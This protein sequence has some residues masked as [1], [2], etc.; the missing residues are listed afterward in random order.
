MKWLFPFGFILLCFQ[1]I[2]AQDAEVINLIPN[3]DFEDVKKLTANSCDIAPKVWQFSG[4]RIVGDAAG[5]NC[6]F[7]IPDT[8]NIKGDYSAGL[9]LFNTDEY[10][11]PAEKSYREYLHIVLKEPLKPGQQYLVKLNALPFPTNI[12]ANNSLGFYFSE[13]STFTT[14]PLI[15][16]GISRAPQ[17]IFP[18]EIGV[19]GTWVSH[20]FVFKP[21]REYTHLTIG[22]F[23]NNSKTRF[24]R[25]DPL[26]EKR[27]L[28][29]GFY[30]LDN[31]ELFEYD[32]EYIQEET[33]PVI[34]ENIMSF[35]GVLFET[36]STT[37]TK[38]F[39]RELI[40]LSIFLIANQQKNITIVGHTDNSGAEALN[41]ELSLQ[42]SV[43][44][45]EFL[46]S[47]SVQPNRI[48]TVGMGDKEPLKPNN[49]PENRAINRRVEI[50][51]D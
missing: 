5:K 16:L 18:F 31:L 30:L 9:W 47:L 8:L 46:I 34:I 13:G 39:S 36:G 38:D 11:N 14:D 48:K 6:D 49:S 29:G 28:Q 24:Q 2:S 27:T 44:V 26:N 43:A 10:E 20:T 12:F 21:D 3:G 35:Q 25:I 19:E 40:R 4:A 1:T 22:N 33:P 7:Q 32:D 51:I 42:R 23:F 41:K 17:L 45:K 15:N 50:I 37:I